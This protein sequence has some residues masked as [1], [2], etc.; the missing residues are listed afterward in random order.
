MALKTILFGALVTCNTYVDG[1]Q[2]C[3]IDPQI[4]IG[5]TCRHRC[6]NKAGQVY[7][8]CPNYPSSVIKG[9]RQHIPT[10][11]SRL[12]SWMSNFIRWSCEQERLNWHSVPQFIVTCNGGGK[13]DTN[14]TRHNLP[15]S[16]ATLKVIHHFSFEISPFYFVIIAQAYTTC[17]VFVSFFH[18]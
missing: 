15:R 10:L 11:L 2:S 4:A 1:I 17:I 9:C 13:E 8:T 16:N 7:N 14:Y 18:I 3:D 5:K 12:F 6:S